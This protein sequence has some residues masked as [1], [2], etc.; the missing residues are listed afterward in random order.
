MAIGLADIKTIIEGI[1][2]VVIVFNDGYL[3][4]EM[5]DARHLGNVPYAEI[6]ESESDDSDHTSTDRMQR[7]LVECRL[8]CRKNIDDYNTFLGRLRAAFDSKDLYHIQYNHVPDFSPQTYAI[9]FDIRFFTT[10]VK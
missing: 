4:D 3:R 2:G 10:V 6:K 8:I 5:V 9:E 7:R 1:A